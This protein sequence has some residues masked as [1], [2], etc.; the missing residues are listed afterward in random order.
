MGGNGDYGDGFSLR[1]VEYG[2]GAGTHVGGVAVFSV[3]GNG[4]HVRFGLRG[5]DAA[6]N[7][8]SFRIDDGNGFVDFGGDV[9]QT[10]FGTDDGT[11]GADAVAEI[12]GVDELALIK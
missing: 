5:R 2:E 6:D 8:Q 10:V 1:E 12:D 11:V 3:C 4:Q 7:L 9:E